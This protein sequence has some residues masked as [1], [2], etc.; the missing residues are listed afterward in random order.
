[1]EVEFT[2]DHDIEGTIVLNV[3]NFFSADDFDDDT[4]ALPANAV[5]VTVIDDIPILTGAMSTG[6]VEEEEA[7]VQGTGNEDALPDPIDAD[8]ATGPDVFTNTTNVA[9]GSLAPLVSVGTDEV[10]DGGNDADFAFVPVDNAEAT[11]LVMPPRLS[12]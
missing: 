8:T 2:R 11:A 6:V 10:T 7:A 1:M 9:S 4:V 12:T 5:K 3:G